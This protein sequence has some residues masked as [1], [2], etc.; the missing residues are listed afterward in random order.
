MAKQVLV[1][2]CL[3]LVLSCQ[4][5]E[6]N[7]LKAENDSLRKEL[8]VCK[9][10]ET[11]LRRKEKE[12]IG[13]I[14]SLETELKELREVG[15]KLTKDNEARKHRIAQLERDLARL[16]EDH[17]YLSKVLEELRFTTQPSSREKPSLETGQKGL[18]IRSGLVKTRQPD[19]RIEYFDASISSLDA[20]RVYLSIEEKRDGTLSL[21]LNIQHG[22]WV[23][24]KDYS[25]VGVALSKGEKTFSIPYNPSDVHAVEQGGFRKETLR[26]LVKGKILEILK[27]LAQG[28]GEIHLLIAFPDFSQDRVLSRLE[29]QG[30]G[31]VYYAFREMGGA[32]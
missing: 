18:E 25:V 12:L 21:F 27:E 1:L 5:T 10:E 30:M 23:I 15:E 7:R 28:E 31:N 17:Q 16:N 29:V 13:R 8:S 32:L 2:G 26:L 6:V 22:Y 3:I 24:R 20:Q 9:N 4:T 11:E 19:G 14:S